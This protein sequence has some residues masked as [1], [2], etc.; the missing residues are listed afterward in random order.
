M[1]SAI[2]VKDRLKNHATARGKTFQEAI[3]ETFEH[4]GTGFD[5]IFAFT[6]DFLVSEIHQNR[7]RAFLKKKKTLINVELEEVVSLL[8]TMLLPIVDGI[9]SGTVFLLKWDHT[10]RSWK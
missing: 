5:D 10:S 4:R 9:K 8:E 1:I 3:K 6:D 7:W 2:S